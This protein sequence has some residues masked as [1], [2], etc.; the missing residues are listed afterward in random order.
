VTHVLWVQGE[1][2]YVKG[3]NEKDYR[4]RFLSLASSV[5]S[6]AVGA[7]VSVHTT[8]TLIVPVNLLLTANHQHH[9]Q[10]KRVAGLG[11]KALRDRSS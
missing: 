8:V 10:L 11:L 5:R 1:I 4:D 2:E 9:L 6:H 3:T 7:P